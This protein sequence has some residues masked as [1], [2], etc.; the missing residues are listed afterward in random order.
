[1]QIGTLIRGEIND[2]MGVVTDVRYWGTDE[3][4]MI[5]W[6][7]IELQSTGWLSTH[8]LEVICS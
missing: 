6:L 3:L 5:Y 2:L 4:V 8:D 7:E 1:M